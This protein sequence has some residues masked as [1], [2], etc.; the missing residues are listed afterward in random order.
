MIAKLE[1]FYTPA[2]KFEQR[3]PL[4]NNTD[5]Y[6]YYIIFP[7]SFHLRQMFERRLLFLIIYPHIEKSSFLLLSLLTFTLGFFVYFFSF[8]LF[9]EK[10]Y[11]GSVIICFW[12]P[13]T[14][15]ISFQCKQFFYGKCCMR[16]LKIWMNK[17]YFFALFILF[18]SHLFSYLYVTHLNLVP[19]H[20]IPEI[21]PFFY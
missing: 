16:E 12:P 7:I 20:T 4:P 6:G 1:Y 9:M 10:I 5:T 17:F 18:Y 2:H 8:Q 14:P 15:S 11:F 21:M 3:R 19:K 13:T